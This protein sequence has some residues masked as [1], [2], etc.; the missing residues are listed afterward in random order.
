[1]RGELLVDSNSTDLEEAYVYPHRH[2][3]FYLVLSDKI[4]AFH[5]ERVREQE[6]EVGSAHV[7]FHRNEKVQ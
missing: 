6:R 2:Y 5:Y 4:M 7:L 1:M 3:C